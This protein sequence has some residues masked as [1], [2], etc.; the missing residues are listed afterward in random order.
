[1]GEI[2]A[3]GHDRGFWRA[4]IVIGG[5]YYNVFTLLK[6]VIELDTLDLCVFP[7]KYAIIRNDV[8]SVKRG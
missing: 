8:L 3:K 4:R 1:M 5:G 7:S 2:S 6:K